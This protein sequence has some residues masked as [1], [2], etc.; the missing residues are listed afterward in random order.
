MSLLDPLRQIE[1]IEWIPWSSSSMT[2]C[3]KAV[4]YNLQDMNY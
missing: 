1:K 4:A 3:T 2:V